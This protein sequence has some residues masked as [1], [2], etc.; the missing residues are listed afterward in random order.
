M[1]RPILSK[2]FKTTQSLINFGNTV[3]AAMN[4]NPAFPAPPVSIADLLDAMEE[5][6]GAYDNLKFTRSRLYA[7]QVATVVP[8]VKSQLTSLGLYVDSV[9][10]GDANIIFSAGMVPTKTRASNPVPAQVANISAYFTGIPGAIKLEWRRPSFAKMFKVYMTEDPESGDEWQLVDTI[11][12]RRLMVEN[13]ERGKRFFFKVVAVGTA[14]IS[15]ESSI[16]EAI[17]A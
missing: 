2:E 9:A 16:A 3:A 13:L 11:S 15:P 6:S 10:A 14:G 12:T 1:K 7:A 5:L 17:A 4:A 8:V